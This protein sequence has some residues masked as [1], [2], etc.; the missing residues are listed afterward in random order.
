MSPLSRKLL[1]AFAVLG[2][3]LSGVS[4]YVHYQLLTQPGYT[5]FCDVSARV[6]CTDAYTSRF[7]S[8]AGVPVALGGVVFFALVIVLV[9]F[10]QRPGSALRENASAYIF[11]LSTVALAFVLYLA[12]A[13]FFILKAVCLLCAGTYVAVI[14]IF[15]ISGG[16]TTFPMTAL[17]RR[18][19]RDLRALM[20]SPLALV[21]LLLFV[22]GASTLVASFPRE[23]STPRQ[24]AVQAPPLTD[25]QRAQIARWY[26]V[27]PK[28]EVPVEADGAK[29]VIVKFNDFQCP[30]CRATYEAFKPVIE[31]HTA[32]GAVKFVLKHF[33]LEG[34]CNASAMG[35]THTAA[36]EAAGAYVLARG[37]GTSAKLEEWLFGHQSTLTPDVV[38]QAA[39]DVGSLPDFDA[40]YARALQEVRTDASLGQLLGVKSTPTFFINGHRIS[41]GFPPQ[42]LEAIIDLELKRAQ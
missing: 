28:V 29:V 30:P 36:C 10:A 13:A 2:L 32:T 20:T 31:R 9:A 18:A 39:R 35:G 3:G 27:Q 37:K 7:G 19:V 25:E 17:P 40:Q 22:A 38:R 26:D 34:E 16:A 21:I 4:S 24:A 1:L 23:S 41:Q 42:V 8:L 14:A 6:S 5:S 11:A 12:W 15:I 33:P